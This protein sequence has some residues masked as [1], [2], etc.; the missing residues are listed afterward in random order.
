MSL[1]TKETTTK[2]HQYLLEDH[3]KSADFDSKLQNEVVRDFTYWVIVPNSFPYDAIATTHHMLVPKRVFSEEQDMTQEE[4]NELLSIKKS[5][6]KG[7][8]YSILME[9]LDSARS[10]KDHF[11]IHIIK[12]KED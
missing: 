12:L 4:Y 11:H 3:N 5:L 6:S 10:I 9:N 8:E 2:Y 7:T 1:R